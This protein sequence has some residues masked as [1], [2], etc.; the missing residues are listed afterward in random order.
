MFDRSHVG[1]D[2]VISLL[3]AFKNDFS[4]VILTEKS[5][6]VMILIQYYIESS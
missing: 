2:G 5:K 3:G 1:S 6:K 4:G